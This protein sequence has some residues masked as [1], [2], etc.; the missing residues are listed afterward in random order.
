MNVSCAYSTF[1]SFNQIPFLLYFYMIIVLRTVQY[2]ST[3]FL[4]DRNERFMLQYLLMEVL[5]KE[6]S[7]DAHCLSLN[8]FYPPHSRVELILLISLQGLVVIFYFNY[9]C[10]SSFSFWICSWQLK[11]YVMYLKGICFLISSRSWV[12]MNT[13]LEL[14]S[15]ITFKR[16]NPCILILWR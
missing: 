14:F 10:A 16:N 15:V 13:L 11:A 3:I 7:R 8:H 12:Y 2:H 5:I 9:W 6:V 4:S 1:E